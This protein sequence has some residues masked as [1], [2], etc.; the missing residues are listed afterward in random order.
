MI[1]FIHLIV[2]NDPGGIR[3]VQSIAVHRHEKHTF[4]LYIVP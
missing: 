2:T 4:L 1:I 3:K